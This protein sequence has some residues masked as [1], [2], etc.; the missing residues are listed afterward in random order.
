MSDT[1]QEFA[2]FW[3]AV[4]ER[5]FAEAGDRFG[6]VGRED[7]DGLLARSLRSGPELEDVDVSG[8]LV[9]FDVDVALQVA[10]VPIPFTDAVARWIDGFSFR[11]AAFDRPP[12][13]RG[14]EA[15]GP[16]ELA[17]GV[18]AGCPA[19]NGGRVDR[20]RR[21]AS[22]PGPVDRHAAEAAEHGFFGKDAFFFGQRA[23]AGEDVGLFVGRRGRN[24]GKQADGEERRGDDTQ[25]G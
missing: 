15:P 3:I 17:V 7:G 24:R 19:V 4:K 13:P 25:A 20:P 12:I 16:A 10:C 8:R 18:V 6:A 1:Y 14:S 5:L 21:H 23:G 22:R 11:A 9:D 2:G